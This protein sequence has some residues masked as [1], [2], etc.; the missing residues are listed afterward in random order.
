MGW[1]KG[2][3]APQSWRRIW[4][5][6][7]PWHFQTLLHQDR[8]E[9]LSQVC[10]FVFYLNSKAFA[11]YHN[12]VL[13]AILYIVLKNVKVFSKGRYI[14]YS[15]NHYLNVIFIQLFSFKWYFSIYPLAK[16]LSLFSFLVYFESSVI[17]HFYHLCNYDCRQVIL[18]IMFKQ[19][20]KRL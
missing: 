20:L 11:F 7:H 15:Y 2:W 1:W 8:T 17:E 18:W 10:L 5:A 6:P 13:F 19:L 9:N 3:W 14:I 16:Q 12:K 4:T